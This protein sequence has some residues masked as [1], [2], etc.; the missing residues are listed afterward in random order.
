MDNRNQVAIHEA[1]EQQTISIAKAGVR[2]TLNARTSILAAA[3]PI[4]GRYDR[5]RSLTQNINL[6][7]PIISRF[8]LFF[9]LVDECDEIVD[10]SIARKIVDLHAN[11]EDVIAQQYTEEEI[12]QYIT[13]AKQF[14]PVISKGAADLLVANY[15][16]LRQKDVGV[17]GKD[18]F[19]VTVR[20]LESMVRLSE[21]MAKM[22]CSNDVEPKHV[23]EAFRL[24]S[25][26][27]IRVEQ[28]DIHLE[29]DEPE[30][31]GMEMDSEN[32]PENGQELT[33]SV[34]SSEEVPTLQKKTVT[35]TFEDY[36]NLTNMIV[37]YIRSDEEAHGSEDGYM[38][39]RQSEV[40]NWYLEKMADQI[41]T[42]EELIER[43]TL[44]DKVIDRLVNNV[45]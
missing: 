33:Q 42:E 45:S 11:K 6:T 20:Q 28:P 27:I 16:H 8:D 39:V 35:L 38:G 18:S 22:E 30:L 12:M 15:N 44:V 21:A 43:K 25:K 17:V 7:A 31:S 32:I 23:K 36:K 24:L 1:M 9:I 14:K 3:N 40:V 10:Y 29:A 2:A 26:S 13:F 41:D 37:T 4:Y 34:P 5:S 19:R